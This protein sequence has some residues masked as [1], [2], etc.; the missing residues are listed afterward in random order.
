MQACVEREDFYQHEIAGFLADF[1]IYLATLN[2]ILPGKRVSYGGTGE[3]R[4]R[5]SSAKPS[6]GLVDSKTEARARASTAARG[7]QDKPRILSA[8]HAKAR[9][10]K[11]RPLS[12][13]STPAMFP[14]LEPTCAL[15][16]NH[17][18]RVVNRAG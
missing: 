16:S 3:A 17:G 15:R 5:P 18:P 9:H 4:C 14:T 2:F 11:P 1:A 6:A 8:Q 7:S 10:N 13:R 12:F